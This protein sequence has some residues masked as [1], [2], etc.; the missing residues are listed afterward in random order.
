MKKVK[1]LVCVVMALMLSMSMMA[2]SKNDDSSASGDSSTPASDVGGM[3]DREDQG[4][5]ADREDGDTTGQEQ[6]ISG[7]VTDASMNT[8]T[9]KT[10]AGDEIT[11]PTEDADMSN[12]DGIA[13]GDE[14][15][16]Y[17]SGTIDGSDIS[18]AKI[19]AIQK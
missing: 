16:V 9:I 15:T 3:A 8:V 17:Y 2:C 6:T 14:V 5:M 18:N 13:N 7:T 4:G 10:D 11:F 12:V 19:I 1:I